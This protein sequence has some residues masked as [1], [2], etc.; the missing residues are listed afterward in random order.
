MKNQYQFVSVD[1]VHNVKNTLALCKGMEL[2]DQRE[3]LCQAAVFEV[4][5]L[6]KA[7]INP[8]QCVRVPLFCSF[9]TKDNKVQYVLYLAIITFFLYKTSVKFYIID[10]QNDKKNYT[11]QTKLWAK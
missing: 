3:T 9:I 5:P 4:Q 8:K 7:L 6:D 2:Q 1:W 11:T 10:P